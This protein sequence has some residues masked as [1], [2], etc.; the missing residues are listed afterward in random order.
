MFRPKSMPRLSSRATAPTLTRL[1]WRMRCTR[2]EEHAM[3]EF[4]DRV[5]VITGGASGI[6]LGIARRCAR[7][8]MRVVLADIEPA[9]LAQAEA[10]LRALGA[11]TRTV[12]ADV[13]KAAEVEALARQALE[14]FGDVHLLCNNAGVGA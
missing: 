12:V 4:R 2:N 14:A 5:A 1:G 8:G 13:S 10:E 9:A 11:Q 7:E 3:Q 6:G